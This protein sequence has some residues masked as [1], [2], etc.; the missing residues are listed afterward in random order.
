MILVD[1]SAWIEYQHATGSL[2]DLRLTRAIETD[3]PLATT[4]LVLPSSS[5]ARATNSTRATFADYSIA[6]A[7]SRSRSLPTTKRR[8]RS[9][10][11]AV[12]REAPSAGSPT[13]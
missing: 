1:T 10:G 11:A 2:A 3:E 8:P 7:S 6:A 4:G 12:A 13:A 9:T 5:P